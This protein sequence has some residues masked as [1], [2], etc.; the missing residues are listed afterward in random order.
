MRDLKSAGNMLLAVLLT[1]T[2]ATGITACLDS[3][4]APAPGSGGGGALTI[5]SNS[6]LI[7]LVGQPYVDTV[8]GSGGTT[9]YVWSV[10]PA[11]PPN[12][13]LNQ[14]TGTIS[15]TP[16]GTS[17][18]DHTFTLKDSSP[19]AVQVQKTLHLSVVPPP[20]VLTIL[21]TTL[22][23]GTINQPYS[24]PLQ[25]AGG[26]GPMTWSLI[27]GSLPPNFSLDPSTGVISG[28]P[29]GTTASTSNFTIQVADTG[30][31][32]DAQALSIRINLPPA[33]TITTTSLPG[34]T[35]GIP[36]GEPV[37]ATGGTGALTWSI[38]AGTLPLPLTINPATGVISGTPGASGT[39]NFTV[40]VTD[41]FPLSDTQALSI[42]IGAA[43]VPPNITTTSLPDGT[44]GTVYNRTL[45]R[46]GGTA[47]FTWS[48]TGTLPPDLNLNPV[49]GVISGTPSAAGTF[50]FTPQ[51]TDSLSLT[52]TTPPGL[53]IT[54]VTPPAPTI[55]T[56]SLPGGTVGT[57]Y[58]QTLQASGG[59]G[60]RVW[61]VTSGSLPSNL[62]LAPTTG[63]ISG[64]P[65]SPGTSAFTVEVT[66]SLSLSDTQNLSI[67]IAAVPVPPTI[68]TPSLPGGTVGTPYSQPVQAT[69]GTGAL[70]WSISAGTLPPP[71]TIDPTSG[72][73]SGAPTTTG[74]F[75]FMVQAVDTVSLSDT[76]ALSIIISGSAPNITT[77][78]LPDG[79]VG[80][81]YNQPLSAT[82]GAG[83]LVW[84]SISGSLPANLSLSPAGVISGT[85]TGTGTANFTVQVTDAFSQTDTQ[86]LS[87]TI[88]STPIP[89]TITTNSPLPTG[90]VGQPYV[91]TTLTATGG[92][93]PYSNWGV[94]PD[95]PTGLT[96]NPST[97]EISGT[98]DTGTE[99]PT[100]HT[101]SVD[102]STS[103]S[104]NKP[105]ISLTIDPP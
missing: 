85:P 66:D 33:P 61:S 15:G 34:G 60:T 67:T 59:T 102:D 53:S 92:T 11:L 25:A 99:G 64:N 105:N 26:T 55:T 57:V 94:T 23:S 54:I 38:S 95:L 80:T 93:P 32:L 22:P 104:V 30:G 68:T 87:I 91:G 98:P 89:L 12:L 70:T 79:T 48:F 86:A 97:G 45:Q 40:Q 100:T 69:G 44:M 43:P 6:L 29:T 77:A 65:T 5:T 58:S 37:Q 13:Q 31:Q 21:T 42:T 16:T 39:F 62:S 56:T 75:N 83:T 103:A 46:S 88:V 14:S 63:V 74:T 2:A 49:T 101:I 28:T 35:V 18:V 50:T 7:G 51:V 17:E 1:L 71:L 73:I 9:P 41:S 96:L 20:P 84:S 24:E 82:G 10:S 4:S 76:K 36:Y 52:D 78:T 8:G 72:V 27:A 3:S 19:L 81:E 90:Q 47:P